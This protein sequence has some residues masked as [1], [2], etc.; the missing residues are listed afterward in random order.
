VL[1]VCVPVTI[2]CVAR[3]DCGCVHVGGLDQLH[4]VG[5]HIEDAAALE[6]RGAASPTSLG[7]AARPLGQQR[8]QRRDQV[9]LARP[10]LLSLPAFKL[11]AVAACLVASV[12]VRFAAPARLWPFAHRPCSALVGSTIRSGVIDDDE[13]MLMAQCGRELHLLQLVHLLR[14]KCGKRTQNDA[15]R[16]IPNFFRADSSRRELLNLTRITRMVTRITRIFSALT[17]FVPFT[18]HRNHAHG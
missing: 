12:R 4:A 7:L 14:T 11:P 8:V 2:F 13:W 16:K 6:S 9:F 1:R 5:Q 10:P 3:R 17:W 18:S 15:F